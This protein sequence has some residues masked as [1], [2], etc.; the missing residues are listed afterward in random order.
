MQPLTWNANRRANADGSKTT[1]FHTKWVNFL[2]ENGEWSPIDCNLKEDDR[3]FVTY[4]APFSFFAPKFSDGEAYFESTCRYDIFK[5]EKIT[6]A[7]FGMYLSAVGVARVQGEIFDMDGNGRSDAVIYKNAYP[8][9]NADLIY[10]VR[11]G[12]APRLEK[13]VRFNSAPS[14]AP[15]PEFKL[16]FSKE[17]TVRDSLKVKV[18]TKRTTKKSFSIAPGQ[19][20][21]DMRGIGMKD[22]YIWD[23]EKGE[24]QKRQSID[25]EMKKET[26]GWMIKKLVPLSFF[27]GA[28]FPVFTD[29]TSTFY[30]DPHTETTSCD[31]I[32]YTGTT[33][34]N[35]WASVHDATN[36]TY[37]AADGLLTGTYHGNWIYGDA[38]GWKRITR[39]F[40]LFDTSAIPDTDTVS[41][42]TLGVYF[43]DQDLA[44]DTGANSKFYV[45][46]STPASNTNITA[47]DFEQLGTTKFNSGLQNSSVT[48]GAINTITLNAS[49][50]AAISKTSISKLGM[51]MGWDV[52]NIDPGFG[53]DS[54]VGGNMRLADNAGTAS[55]PI[56]T[57]THASAIT[58]LGLERSPIRSVMRGAMRP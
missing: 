47:D 18:V 23:S 34:Y 33:G 50:I 42:A 53:G 8:Q 13:L 22:F 27:S 26:S 43:E 20:T 10:Y 46:A 30:P 57:V 52:D 49:G 17:H 39:V 56:L 44:H 2:A 55:D 38:A 11:H 4:D 21:S 9:W 7:P 51:R 28:V 40:L 37:G 24:H 32:A 48:T 41:A 1:E 5:K 58:L 54:G 15:T 36:G 45:V 19:R 3:G 14:S 31:G 35:T 16:R 12:R 6:D 25:V 29:T